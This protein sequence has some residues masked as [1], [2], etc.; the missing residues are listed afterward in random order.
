[1][2]KQELREAL[3]KIS[4]YNKLG[5]RGHGDLEDTC[6]ICGISPAN[7]MTL[8]DQALEE[9]RSKMVARMQ[10]EIID[11]AIIEEYGTIDYKVVAENALNFVE[12]QLTK[13]ERSDV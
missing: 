13:P 7:L 2:T 3:N 4:E 10:V 9:Q 5:N 8:F 11:P 12:A 6:H 1:M